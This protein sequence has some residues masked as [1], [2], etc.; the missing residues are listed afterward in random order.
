MAL[1]NKGMLWNTCGEDGAEALKRCIFPLYI[2]IF[3]LQVNDLSFQN[4]LSKSVNSD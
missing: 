2:A 3:N 1:G 4:T